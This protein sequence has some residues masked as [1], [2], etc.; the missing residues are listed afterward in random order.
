V[1]TARA[2]CR[3]RVV[4]LIAQGAKGLLLSRRRAREEMS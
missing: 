3:V 1:V 4:M 2:A